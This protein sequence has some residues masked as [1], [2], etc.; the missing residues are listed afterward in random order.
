LAYQATTV[1]S[2]IARPHLGTVTA[3]IPSATNVIP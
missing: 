1:P 2:V 3:L